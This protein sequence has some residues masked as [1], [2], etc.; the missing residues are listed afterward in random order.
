MSFDHRASFEPIFGL[1]V[2]LCFNRFSLVSCFVKN[3]SGPIPFK[4][5]LSYAFITIWSEPDIKARAFEPEPRLFSIP[6]NPRN[7][8]CHYERRIFILLSSFIQ[9]IIVNACCLCIE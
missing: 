9:R 4:V 8:L 6:T 7:V 1:A 3:M 2:I 5:W